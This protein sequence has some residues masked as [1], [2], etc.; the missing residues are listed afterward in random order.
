MGYTFT[1][2]FISVTDGVYSARGLSN[3]GGP[4]YNVNNQV[5]GQNTEFVTGKKL[6]EKSV[7]KDYSDGWKTIRLIRNWDNY[8]NPLDFTI[9]FKWD[10]VGSVDPFFKKL[11]E[12]EYVIDLTTLRHKGASQA[13]QR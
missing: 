2:E 7:V 4:I 1:E 3:G 12:T 5:R 10:L 11:T 8:A 6:A 9:S 13:V